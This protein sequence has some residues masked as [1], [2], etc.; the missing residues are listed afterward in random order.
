[1]SSSSMYRRL[2]LQL[3]KKNTSCNKFTDKNSLYYTSTQRANTQTHN[4]FS[5]ISSFF[6]SLLKFTLSS[7]H[8]HSLSFVV[9][10][11]FP[12][13]HT[14]IRYN[15]TSRVKSNVTFFYRYLL[16]QAIHWYHPK[17]KKN[18]K[19][20]MCNRK[21]KSLAYCNWV[22]SDTIVQHNRS[23]LNHNGF[24]VSQTKITFFYVKSPFQLPLIFY[25]LVQPP[26]ALKSM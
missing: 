21:W 8:T 15:R 17:K 12:Q 10:D 19:T 6:F 25:S 7:S 2:A 11:C 16:Y 18:K 1:M 22:Q 20:V 26:P 3:E 24:H 9:V 23:T 5:A 4:P 14:T 13:L